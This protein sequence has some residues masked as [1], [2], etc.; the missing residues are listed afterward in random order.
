MESWL[1]GFIS[2]MNAFSAINGHGPDV[3]SGTD[4]D[5][6]FRWMDNYCAAHPLEQV[7]GAAESLIVELD[8]RKAKP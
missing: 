4:L 6:I 3:T 2:A 8:K 1:G 5:G 7:S